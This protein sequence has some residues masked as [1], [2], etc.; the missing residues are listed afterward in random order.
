MILSIT[1]NSQSRESLKFSFNTEG[2]RVLYSKD[3]SL[4]EVEKFKA[5]L[6]FEPRSSF[7][8]RWIF[9]LR[10]NFFFFQWLSV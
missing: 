8:S 10:V 2:E 7:R 1:F 5:L 9:D 3:L 6:K 4:L